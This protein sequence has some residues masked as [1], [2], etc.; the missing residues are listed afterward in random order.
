MQR[1]GRLYAG[2]QRTAKII[3]II[4]AQQYSQ[5]NFSIIF[6]LL[7]VFFILFI[8]LLFIYLSIKLFMFI[9]SFLYYYLGLIIFVFQFYISL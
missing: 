2:E 6:I 5:H 8:G 7:Y 3:I 4:L 1:A 9:I